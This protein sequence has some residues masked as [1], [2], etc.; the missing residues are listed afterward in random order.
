MAPSGCSLRELELH[1]ITKLI[2]V[3]ILTITLRKKNIREF[4]RWFCVDYA[5][6]V[7]LPT[8]RRQKK[9]DLVAN[10]P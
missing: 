7:L 6:A 1:A 9:W 3:G 5:T 4:E 10:E 8:N 2:R